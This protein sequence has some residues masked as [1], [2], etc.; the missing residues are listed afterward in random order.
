MPRMDLLTLTPQGL[1][2]EAGGFHVDPWEPVAHAVTTH[3]HADHARAGHGRVTCTPETAA[4]LRVRLGEDTPLE[5]VPCGETRELG[6]TRVSL[7]PAGHVL[8]SAQVRVDGPGGVWVVS[9]DYKR[10]ED[11]TCAPFE[12]VP[13]DVFITEATFGLPI[14][15]WDPPDV[16]LG[17]MERFWRDNAQAGQATVFLCYALGKAQRVLNAAARWN[18]PRILLHG[19]MET[20]LPVYRDAGVAFPETTLATTLKRGEDTAGALVLAPPSAVGTPWMRRFK[21]CRVALC[22]GWTRVRAQRKRGALDT[23]FALSDH[24]DWP[25]LLTTVEQT[26]ARRVLVTHGH[27]HPLARWLQENGVNAAQLST[28]FTGEADL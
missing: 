6:R 7:H 26:G 1:W 19:A 4:I 24:A 28:P 27:A 10:Q 21:D 15:R 14:Y 20:L 22:S 23:G 2:C 5:P 25:G 11:P 16:V 9:G 17:D 8:G 13:C 3:A 12:V 18:V